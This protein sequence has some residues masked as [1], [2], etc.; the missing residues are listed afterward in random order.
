[1]CLLHQVVILGKGDLFACITP[2]IGT[3][4]GN[5]V[6]ASIGLGI[7]AFQ[8]LQNAPA[9]QY[10]VSRLNIVTGLHQMGCAHLQQNQLINTEHGNH[11]LRILGLA[12]REITVQRRI[13]L[14]LSGGHQLI[15]L[16]HTRF[17]LGSQLA[18]ADISVILG[19]FFQPFIPQ[20]R[21][22]GIGSH[23]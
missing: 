19:I 16:Q 1:M 8:F 2:G 21:R 15:S 17:Q 23:S 6:V 7:I 9:N 3:G 10:I 20:F 5:A 22:V 13:V 12:Q 4:A 11:K 14:Q 18:V